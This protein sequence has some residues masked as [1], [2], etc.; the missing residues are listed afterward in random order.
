MLAGD[1]S[2]MGG[3]VKPTGRARH[4]V[5]LYWPIRH[6]CIGLSGLHISFYDELAA[7]LHTSAIVMRNHE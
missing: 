7:Y 1:G 6:F 3:R 2:I 4:R 5:F